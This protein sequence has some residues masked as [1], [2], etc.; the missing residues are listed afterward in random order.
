MVLDGGS[1]SVAP[2]T[3]L[4]LVGALTWQLTATATV[5][6]DGLIELGSAAVLQETL[7]APITGTGTERAERPSP[8]AV[9]NEEPG[10]LGIAMSTDY[11]GGGIVVE[12]GHAPLST[13]SG[14]ESIAR[15]YS[16]T[17]AQ[18]NAFPIDLTFRYDPTELNGIAPNLLSLFVAAAANG[19]WAALTTVGD[20]PTYSLVATDPDAVPL[21]T[22]FDADVVMGVRTAP[23][24][25]IAVWPTLFTD[26]VHL[27]I[28]DRRSVTEVALLDAAGRVVWRHRP[29]VGANG[30]IVLTIPEIAPGAYV[31]DLGNGQRSK[32]IR[33]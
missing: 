21:I 13:L 3:T 22:A 1:L 23:A 7:G 2:G 31:L 15:W 12:R 24:D 5:V 14:V 10:G 30:I 16:I 26:A 19:P 25:A 9:S 18:T 28:P 29:A 6:N 33:E 27:S 17:M 11:A 4:E 8:T 20:A 32:L